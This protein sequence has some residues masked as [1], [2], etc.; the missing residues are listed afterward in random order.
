[1]SFTF[2]LTYFITSIV[3]YAPKRNPHRNWNEFLRKHTKPTQPKLNSRRLHTKVELSQLPF[4]CARMI[5]SFSMLAI[6][7]RTCASAPWFIISRITF[8]KWLI[9]WQKTQSKWECDFNSLD[10]DGGAGRRMKNNPLYYHIHYFVW[11]EV[12]IECQIKE[13]ALAKRIHG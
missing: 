11:V 8:L 3:N 10:R 12:L 1:M 13:T 7:P 5:A 2:S 6:S 4:S 9:D